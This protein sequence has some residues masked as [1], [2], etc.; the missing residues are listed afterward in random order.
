MAQNWLEEIWGPIFE[1]EEK[2]KKFS[3][4]EAYQKKEL[5]KNWYEGEIDKARNI[6]KHTPEGVKSA[7]TGTA[8]GIGQAYSE[9]MWKARR[10][11]LGPHALVGSH[12][13]DT[14]GKATGAVTE[15]AT[16]QVH[17]KLGIHK[18]LAR[19][20]VMAAEALLSRKIPKGLSK[21]KQTATGYKEAL[22]GLGGTGGA[23]ATRGAG[24]A[25]RVGSSVPR[26]AKPVD[27]LWQGKGTR[28]GGADRFSKAESASQFVDDPKAFTTLKTKQ[29]A[30]L[31]GKQSP[32]AHHHI[33]DHSLAGRLFNRVDAPEI[34]KHLK[35]YGVRLGDDERNI[36]GLMDEKLGSFQTELRRGLSKQAPNA[37]VREIT[38]LAKPPVTNPLRPDEL[39]PPN[40][41]GRYTYGAG[42]EQFEG[43]LYSDRYKTWG[44]NR[45]QI[46]IDPE[47]HILGRDHLDIV[48]RTQELP[49]FGPRT[50]NPRIQLLKLLDSGEYWHM[51]PKEAAKLIAE[52]AKNQRNI[53][54]NTAQWRMNLIKQK[55]G[56]GKIVDGK[57]VPSKFKQAQ[58]RRSPEAIRDWVLKNPREAAV[59]GWGKS[60]P[61]IKDLLKPHGKVTN[62]VKYLFN[63]IDDAPIM[64]Q[65]ESLMRFYNTPGKPWNIR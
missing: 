3:F 43:Q 40:I 2:A 44:I 35:K 16:E 30:G 18:P 55:M 31:G 7:V 10:G 27:K 45:K 49:M 59:L 22:Y 4:K 48:H 12:A 5:G 53:A 36:I 34:D 57:F 29:L 63:V 33:V 42:P 58:M 13:I 51:P 19:G 50:P 61:K 47:K 60:A 65:Y 9:T 52:V 38:D 26:Y 32:F 14:I 8:S 24:K 46:K 56:L 39:T 64:K 21:I 28:T 17:D 23:G 54:L 1:K 15:F 62:E 41:K 20:G 37:S 11:M 6:W 25:L